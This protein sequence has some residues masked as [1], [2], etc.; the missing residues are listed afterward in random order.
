MGVFHFSL[1][2]KLK[3]LYDDFPTDLSTFAARFVE[4]NQAELVSSDCKMVRNCPAGVFPARID[5]EQMY[6]VLANLLDNALRYA[7]ASPLVLTLS[8]WQEE[9]WV[10]LRFADNGN[11]VPEDQLPHLFDQFWRGDQAR[12][13]SGQAL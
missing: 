13:S 2:S 6:R 7:G 5:T 9:D 8:L 3:F 4:D 10:G 1:H 12:R 11:G